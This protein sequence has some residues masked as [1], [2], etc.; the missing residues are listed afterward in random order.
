MLFSQSQEDSNLKSL[1]RLGNKRRQEAPAQGQDEPPSKGNP[2][3]EMME[4][5]EHRRP[6]SSLRNSGEPGVEGSLATGKRSD[7]QTEISWLV[8]AAKENF[9]MQQ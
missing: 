8:R 3:P 1:Q 4:T 2:C 5:A 9:V 7:S 6:V